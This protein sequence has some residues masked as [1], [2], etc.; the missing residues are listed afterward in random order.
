MQVG[1]LQ[2]DKFN[3]ISQAL[4]QEFLAFDYYERILTSAMADPHIAI[5]AKGQARPIPD[6]FP[7]IKIDRYSKGVRALLNAAI[8]AKAKLRATFGGVEAIPNWK[9][10]AQ[11]IAEVQA[12]DITD[13]LLEIEG[14]TEAKRGAERG[15]QLANSVLISR[16]LADMYD[17]FSS[18][19]EGVLLVLCTH[20]PS[21]C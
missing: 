18:K 3:I 2:E 12:N 7:I 4:S 17:Q 1:M 10:L 8:N 15:R 20:V 9:N 21:R 11:Y 16:V 6:K 13:P 5:A 19:V 14:D